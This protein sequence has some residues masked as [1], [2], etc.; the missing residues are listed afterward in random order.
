MQPET[1]RRKYAEILSQQAALGQ[2]LVELQREC[3]HARVSAVKV[4]DHSDP[5]TCG[6]VDYQCKDCGKVSWDE[7]DFHE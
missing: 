5:R 3:P 6:M 1:A 4:G 2:Q 7:R